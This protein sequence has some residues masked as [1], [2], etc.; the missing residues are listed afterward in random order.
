MTTPIAVSTMKVINQRI[1]PFLII[2]YFMANLDKTNISIAALQMNADLGLTASMYGFGV[3]IFYLSYI[4]FEIPSNIFMVRVGPRIWLMRIMLTWGIISA[5]MSLVQTPTQLYIMRFLLGMAEAGFTPCVIWYLSVWF[6]K[7][8]RA[9]A[10]SLF[11]MGS[12]L[13]SVVGLPASGAILNMHGI[14]GV[15][16]WRWLFAIEGIPAILLGLAALRYIANKP[17]QVTWLSGEQKQWLSTTLA[18]DNAS[19]ELDDKQ[20]W[21]TAL[22]NKIVIILSLVWFLQ[23]FGTIG[24]TLFLPL[25]LQGMN[26][27]QSS[28]TIGLLSSLPFALACLFM[29]LNGRHSDM[30]KERQY[31]LGLPLIIA[32]VC[33]T[34]AIYSANP[35]VSYGLLVCAVGCNFALAPVFWAVTTEKISGLAAAAS[36]AFINTIANFAGLG[37]PPVFGRIK[38][39]TGDYNYGLLMVAFA[40][41]LGGI[42]GILVARPGPSAA[43]TTTPSG[44]QQHDQ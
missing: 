11:F 28:F 29:Y 34:A 9:R 33:L 39:M 15:P 3:G 30:R 43:S 23:A 40:L 35:W 19:V 8:H 5:G 7:S 10:M 32:G 24:I 1:I 20:R 21:Y 6:P 4:I 16:G 36:I 37:L 12:V 2:C 41:L 42:L 17:D 18:K 27:A 13:A 22:T 26:V 38:D 44:E 25:I 14:A 31:H